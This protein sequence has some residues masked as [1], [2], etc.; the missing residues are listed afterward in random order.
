[1]RFSEKLDIILAFAAARIAIVPMQG[2]SVPLGREHLPI[3]N[4][5]ELRRHYRAHRAANYGVATGSISEVVVVAV[6]GDNGQASL[7]ALKRK[8]GGSLPKTT[9]MKIGSRRYYLF[10]TN[11][12][13]IRSSDDLLGKGIDIYGDND[14]IYGSGSADQSGATC[15]FIKG[16]ALR[17][18]GVAMAPDWL[19]DLRKLRSPTWLASSNPADTVGHWT[20]PIQLNF[21]FPVPASHS[22]TMFASLKAAWGKRQQNA[23]IHASDAVRERF[24]KEVLPWPGKR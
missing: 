7:R 12:G 10:R 21:E 16:R 2:T 3:R 18:I 11:G 1:M 24:V 15:R 22:E 17:D 13:R 5:N 19:R 20:A 9:T 23:W 14:W 8:Y 6:D 4:A